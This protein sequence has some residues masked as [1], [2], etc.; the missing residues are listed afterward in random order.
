[1]G[2]NELGAAVNTCPLNIG[3]SIERPVE[4]AFLMVEVGSYQGSLASRE[5]PEHE[6]SGH[7]VHRSWCF[8]LCRMSRRWWTTSN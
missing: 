1:M 3:D 2:E 4:S 8:A 7:A 5:K 6:D